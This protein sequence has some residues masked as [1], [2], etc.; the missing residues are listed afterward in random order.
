VSEDAFDLARRRAEMPAGACGILDARSLRTAHRRLAELLVEGLHVLDVGCGTGAITRG[1]AERVGPAGRVIGLDVC[2]ALIADARAKHADVPGLAFVVGDVYRLP[3][4][5]RFDVVTAARVL[6]WLSQ[7]A[8]ALRAMRGA[9]KHGGHV[10]VLD[11]NHE[12]IAWKPRPPAS[13]EAFYGAFLRWRADAGMDN[14]IADHLADLFRRADLTD[15]VV[16]P[17]HETTERGDEE[18]EARAGIWAEVAATRG[19]QMVSDGVISE[20]ER[21]T[22]Q[23]DYRAWLRDDAKAQTMYLLAVEGI[24]P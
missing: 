19:H 8:A 4:A 6:Q 15:I 7:P 14:A 23:A 16:V 2:D 11:Y 9:A 10:V 5:A 12:K 13:M 24:R 3:S 21:A 1:I 22:A 20:Q 18:F 17:Q